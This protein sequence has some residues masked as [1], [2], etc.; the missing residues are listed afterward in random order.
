MQRKSRVLI[1]QPALPN[2]RVPFFNK[3]GE[4]VINREAIVLAS[5]K[6]ENGVETTTKNSSFETIVT[7]PSKHFFGFSFQPLVVR[8]TLNLRAGDVLVICG[9]PRYVIN[10]LMTWI[11][12]FRGVK[13]IW[14]GQLWSANTSKLSLRIK[15]FLMQFS[16][17]IILYN[18]REEKLL[19]R[20]SKLP[21]RINTYYLNNGIDNSEITNLRKIY[22]ANERDKKI[23]FIGRLTEKSNFMLLLEAVAHLDT[24]SLEVVGGFPDKEHENFMEKLG[25]SERVKFHGMLTNETDISVIANKCSLFVYPGAVGLSLIHAFNY[26]LPA[27]IH[28]E[29][30]QHM[31]EVVA[32]KSGRNGAVFEKGSVD[33]LVREIDVLLTSK[34][35]LNAYSNNAIEVSRVDYNTQAMAERFVK[36]INKV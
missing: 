31:P 34:E 13:V 5:V 21:G 35:R 27:I 28:G 3:V 26:G 24:V 30:K 32:F 1:V 15:V 8:E 9:N 6:D 10:M 2:Y 19:R 17:V 29:K 18:E 14:W 16:D 4:G 36:V 25:I 12:R 23:L 33:S 7:S 22:D 11:V 20:L